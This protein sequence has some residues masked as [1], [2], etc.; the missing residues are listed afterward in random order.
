MQTHAIAQ[1]GSRM[2]GEGRG[3]HEKTHAH[4][5]VPLMQGTPPPPPFPLG[6]SVAVAVKRMQQLSHHAALFP[7]LNLV[8]WVFLSFPLLFFRYGV[9]IPVCDGCMRCWRCCLCTC[10]AG[11]FVLA[12]S[13]RSG[14]LVFVERGRIVCVKYLETTHRFY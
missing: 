9:G 12:S 3:E 13:W 1:R 6:C 2:H 14:A 5:Y 11:G 4:Q 10:A 8:H 7:G